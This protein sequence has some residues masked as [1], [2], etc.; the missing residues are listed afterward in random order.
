MPAAA[1]AIAVGGAVAV[2]PL[3]KAIIGANGEREANAPALPGQYAESFHYWV[4]DPERYVLLAY[5]AP[6]GQDFQLHKVTIQIGL[7]LAIACLI[8]SPASLFLRELRWARPWLAAGGLFTGLGVWTTSSES[9]A[10]IWLSGLWYGV[11]E[12]L[13]SMIFPSY[14]ILAVAGAVALAIGVQRL[15][16]L[17]SRRRRALPSLL[18]PAVASAALVLAL[19]VLTAFPGTWRP[20][21]AELKSRSPVGQS[22]PHAFEW[23]AE[24]TPPGKVVAYDRHREFMTW[25][26]A[27]YKVPLLFGIPPLVGLDTANYVERW[28]AW[29]WLVDN[30]GAKPAG[31]AVRRF[32]VEYLIVG[33]QNM[34]GAW[35]THYKRGRL[36][37]SD[38][39]E[40]VHQVS[41]IKIYRVTD[42]G[43]ACP[44]AG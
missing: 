32:G 30:E 14:G 19:V 31:C 5:P 26:Y 11:R 27:D 12:R 25:S 23:L 7:V 3:L 40:L 2:A 39:I 24:H 44:S 38:R 21:R 4:T 15:A 28:D 41:K 20:I 36:E 1:G 10:A 9:S 8:A 22:Y 17:I 42:R 37:K 33:R 35:E 29:N 43:R 13:R 34:P 16:A 6:G 18:P